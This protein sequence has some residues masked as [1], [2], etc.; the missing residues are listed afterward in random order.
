MSITDTPDR[1]LQVN[2]AQTAAA[3]E[4]TGAVRTHRGNWTGAHLGQPQPAGD[5]M[6]HHR[7]RRSASRLLSG[8]GI[9]LMFALPV[10][11]FVHDT[12]NRTVPRAVAA[13]PWRPT[14]PPIILAGRWN[15]GWALNGHKPSAL[16]MANLVLTDAITLAPRPPRPRVIPAVLTSMPTTGWTL[17][18][19]ATITTDGHGALVLRPLTNG[20]PSL[21]GQGRGW[22]GAYWLPLNTANWQNYALRVTVTNLGAEGSGGT[23][24]VI[25]G[26]T[27]THVGYAVSI[28]AARITIQNQNGGRLFTGVIPAATS[29]RVGVTLAKQL[30]VTIDGSLIHAF[31]TGKAQGGIGFGVYKPTADSNLP[32]FTN[33]RVGPK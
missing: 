32:F 10:A 5:L 29:H 17:D 33:L 12:F 13:A 20:R 2:T 26:H 11:L 31:H 16:E 8:V 21:A 22:R 14:A 18:N 7:V 3:V 28:S 6:P 19:G 1:D 9:L 23:A 4:A 24:T 15:V 27:D 25:V 30:L